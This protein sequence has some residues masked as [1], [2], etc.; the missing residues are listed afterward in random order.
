MVKQVSRAAIV[1]AA[2][3][4]C[5]RTASAAVIGVSGDIS[6]VPTPTSLSY[7]SSN[8]TSGIV[9]DDAVIFSE[10]ENY[11]VPYFSAYNPIF[12]VD[13]FPLADG[14]LI[15]SGTAVNSY[16]VHFD[17]GRLSEP[18]SANGSISFDTD[19]LG[20]QLAL[21]F[22]LNS[23]P[24]PS[25]EQIYESPLINL[26]NATWLEVCPVGGSDPTCDAASISA[27]RRT[28]SFSL[29]T[30]GASDDFRIFEVAATPVPEPASIMLLGSGLVGVVSR[31]RTRKRT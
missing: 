8:L 3:L 25:K 29:N 22:P 30:F 21:Q 6:L 26:L 19:I 15:A 31:V 9:N 14:M 27:D 28:V 5:A 2:A 23:G 10:H 13:A 18:L 16:I 7:Q 20:I 12:Q 11:E 4:C 1:V 24:Q 17:T